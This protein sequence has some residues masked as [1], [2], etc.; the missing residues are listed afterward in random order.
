M[1]RPRRALVALGV[2]GVLWA[3]AGAALLVTGRDADP[4]ALIVL[5][6]LVGVLFLLV[7][8]FVWDRRPDN[9]MGVILTATGFAWFLQDLLSARGPGL[10]TAGLLLNGLSLPVSFTLVTFPTGRFVTRL[11]RWVVTA[12][13]LWATV[14]VVVSTPFNEPPGDAGGNLLLITDVPAVTVISAA[15]WGLLGA[16]LVAALVWRWRVSTPRSAGRWRPWWRRA[17]RPPGSSPSGSPCSAPRTTPR[18]R[19]P[20]RAC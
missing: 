9:R 4:A 15:G 6:T 5:R 19:M 1:N 17:A 11:E 8:L 16:G 3:A 10:Y 7:G 20:P 12:A 13:W 14:W 18:P 2:L